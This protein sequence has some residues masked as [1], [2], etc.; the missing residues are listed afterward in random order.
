MSNWTHVAGV[1]RVDAIRE[2]DGMSAD[3]IRDILGKEVHFDSKT[4]VWDDYYK[5]PEEYLPCGSEGSLHMSIWENPN[6][7]Q[8]P[9]Y[10]VSIFGD[11]RD[12]D[13]AM[14]IVKWFRTKTLVLNAISCGVRNACITARNE[15]HGTESWTYDDNSSHDFI[16]NNNNFATLLMDGIGVAVCFNDG[17][18][19]NFDDCSSA[20]RRLSDIGYRALG[21]IDN[22]ETKDGSVYHG[23]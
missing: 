15:C 7:S 10:V 13:S 8:I 17:S 2:L 1:V 14:E 22:E 12:H 20:V 6:T 19:I 18:V 16:D 11:L 23:I 5:H 21:G 3:K 4:A 9:A